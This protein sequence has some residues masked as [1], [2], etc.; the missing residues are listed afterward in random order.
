MKA[1]RSK[2]T[3]IARDRELRAMIRPILRELTLPRRMNAELDPGDPLPLS[4][5]VKFERP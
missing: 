5:P 4:I 1:R 3:S 2:L